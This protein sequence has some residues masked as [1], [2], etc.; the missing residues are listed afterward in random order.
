MNTETPKKSKVKPDY[1][2]GDYE[3]QANLL[4]DYFRKL[5]ASRVAVVTKKYEGI[6]EDLIREEARKIKFEINGLIEQAH[7]KLAK[8]I[9]KFY[10][11][12]H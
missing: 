11:F 1:Y 5:E 10:G 7:Y 12:N 9:N 4:T 3:T 2:F 6:S 8:R